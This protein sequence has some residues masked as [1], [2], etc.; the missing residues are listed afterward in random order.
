M[1]TTLGNVESATH[2]ESPP[3]TAHVINQL[4][5]L[6]YERV[7]VGMGECVGVGVSGC[8]CREGDRTEVEYKQHLFLD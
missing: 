1:N 7:C 6:V 8:W 4:T 5:A 3:L 2:Q